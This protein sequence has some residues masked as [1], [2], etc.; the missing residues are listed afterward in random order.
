[1]TP[2]AL[3]R[4]TLGLVLLLAATRAGA[5]EAETVKDLKERG[6]EVTQTKGEITG[7]SFRDCSKLGEEEFRQ[8]GKLPHLK[9]L[10]L[11]GHCKGLTDKTLAHLTGL[12]ELEEL[13]T[14]QIQVTDDGLKQL[15][16]LKNLRALSF[17]HVSF[18]RKQFTG[19]GLAYFAD[20]P[21]LER[22]TIAGTPFNDEG[23]EALGQLTQLKEVGTWHTGQTAAGMD[24]LKNLK[25]LTKLH[26]GQRLYDGKP[27]LTD[28]TV[29]VLAEL[30][31]LESLQLDEARLTRDALA[32]LKQLPK[33]KKLT[34]HVIDIPEADVEKLRGDLPGVEVKWDKPDEK[35]MK[36]IGRFFDK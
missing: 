1:M 13:H 28:E 29:A 34:L 9:K 5:G 19:K 6:A 26:L 17:F 25:N 11:Y 4:S 8:I 21:K 36:Y 18:G 16:A 31:A 2:A 22:L 23:M 24:H 32:R 35:G 20:L 12:A 15:T 30:K 33:L 14:D 10:V 27:S 3:S 7:L